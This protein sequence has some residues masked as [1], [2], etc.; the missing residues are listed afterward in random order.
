M[1]D[2]VVIRMGHTAFSNLD[3][4][5]IGCVVVLLEFIMT[6]NYMYVDLMY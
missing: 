4:T 1:D 3:K 2:T 5:S 6:K